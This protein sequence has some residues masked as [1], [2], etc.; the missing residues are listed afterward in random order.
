MSTFSYVAVFALTAM[1]VNSL[2]IYAIYKN[3]EWAEKNKEYF[4][5]FAAGILITSPLIGAFPQAIAKNS[6]AGFFA[7][8][9][10]M[11]MYAT[12]QLMRKNAKKSELAFGYTALV[13]IG[14][15]SFVDGM[16]YSVTFT[17][18]SFLGIIAGTGLVAHEFAEGVITYSFLSKGGLSEKKAIFYAFLVAALTTPLGAFIIYPLLQN[19][20]SSIMGLL[21]GFV[22]GVLIY[23]SASHLLPEASGHEKEH[24]YISFISGVAFAILLYFIK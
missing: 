5:C 17:Q 21:L 24:S 12:N 9:G 4:M 19:F 23:I 2:G 6:E 14:I 10:F 20:T 8:M 7:L 3:K 16:I 11:F 15:H 1:V 13:G 22:T 18:S